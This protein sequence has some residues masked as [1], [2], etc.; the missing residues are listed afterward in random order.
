M[1]WPIESKQ[2]GL[3]MFTMFYNVEQMAISM[4]LLTEI[5]LNK[6]KILWQI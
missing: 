3:C 5:F 6:D 2:K 4:K 1:P